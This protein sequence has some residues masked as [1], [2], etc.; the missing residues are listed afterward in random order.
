MLIIEVDYL[1]GRAV[2]SDR[3]SRSQAE[4]PPHPQRLFSAFV[5]AMYEGDFGEEAREALEWLES[6][7]PPEMLVPESARRACFETYVPVNDNN[8][9]IVLNQRKGTLKYISA[10][11][12]GIAI[13][14]DRKE[15]FF[16]TVI[17]F[18]SIVQFVWR[19]IDTQQ[20]DQHHSVLQSLCETV[21]YLGHSSSLVRIAIADELADLPRW[22]PR[23]ATDSPRIK[24]I[25]LRGLAAGRLK[26]LDA[27][28][29]LSTQTNRR[30]EATDAPW[31]RYV[32]VKH[33]DEAVDTSA[34]AFGD[35]RNWF[36]FKRTSGKAIPLHACL[37][38]T[39]SV[40]KA[41]CSLSDESAPAILTGHEKD[42]SPL[43]S[44][45]VAFLPLANTGYEY[46]RGEIHGFAIVLPRSTSPEDR[47]Q[48]ART[49]GELREVWNSESASD[50]DLCFNWKVD[51][52]SPDD[53][54]KS[55]QP[56]RYMRSSRCWATT[57]PMVFGHFLRKLD[58][59]RTAKIVGEACEAIGLP[60]PKFVHVSPVAMARGV[61]PSFRFPS[62]SS[63]GKPV[64]VRYRNG[65][66]T[67]PKRVDDGQV[68]RMRYHV[69][70]EFDQ[71]VAGP[72]ILGAG[73]H[74]G[75]GLCVPIQGLQIAKRKESN[76]EV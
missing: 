76:H 73:R 27:A 18:D 52:T 59:P 57:T 33:D 17:P 58:E 44:N 40:R 69:A 55:L 60:L 49:L 56:S 25:T 46:S 3:Q 42:G 75:M 6:L 7:E 41:V 21:G 23:R 24:D 10:I 64:W 5:A 74:Y 71:P 63:N 36:V 53:S 19:D 35:R 29:R 70:V 20:L 47:Q 13:G 12:S 2:A 15:R 54:L 62:L 14:R 1:T 65:K 11:D 16:P 68:V 43:A 34:N 9:Q 39:Q 8:Q 50:R 45:H 31:H 30:R 28:F 32:E 72:V 51:I 4:W 22:R 38:L 48:I 37:A 66:Y 26:Q 67:L 61:P